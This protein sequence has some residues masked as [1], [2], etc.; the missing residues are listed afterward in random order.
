MKRKIVA[1]AA[2]ALAVGGAGGAVAA[3]QFSSS[4]SE[5]SQAVITDAAKKLGVQPSALSS[6]LKKALEDRVDAAV[7]A[8]RMSKAEG[9]KLK[10]MIESNDFPLLAGPGFGFGLEHHV[11][12]LHAAAKYLGLTEEQLDQTLESGKTLAQV[13]KD[14]GKSVDG[15]VAALKADLQSKLDEPVSAGR[16]TKAQE[17]Q[18]LKDADKR[19]SDFVN[20]KLL[21]PPPFGTRHFGFGERRGFDDGPEAAFPGA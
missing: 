6:A 8:G 15:L 1:G 14:Q 19:I 11:H 16:L 3:T 4:P 2:A 13:A 7:A 10:Q 21:R 17:D 9:D 5:E 12:G 18:I 20:G